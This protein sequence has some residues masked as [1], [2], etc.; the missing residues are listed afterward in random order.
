[1]NIRQEG[2]PESG[3]FV[4]EDGLGEIV[5]SRAQDGIITVEHTEVDPSLKG[6]NVGKQLVN[7]V[8]D[9]ARKEH[10]KVIPQC[11]YAR[12]VMQ[13]DPSFNDILYHS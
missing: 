2:N 11:T 1:M 10:L 12:A 6:K 4:T 8:A 13:K 5:Y 9:W 3:K 7:A